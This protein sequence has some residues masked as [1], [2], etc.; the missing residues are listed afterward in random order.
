MAIYLNTIFFL[1][2]RAIFTIFLGMI[3][4]GDIMAAMNKVADIEFSV[5]MLFKYLNPRFHCCGDNLTFESCL[6]L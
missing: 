6:P 4:V 2:L 1:L 5:P 3:R